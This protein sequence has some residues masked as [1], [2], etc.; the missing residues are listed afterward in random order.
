M[1]FKNVIK[2]VAFIAIFLIILST[3]S[4]FFQKYNSQK[5]I[6]Y[7]KKN[8]IDYLVLGDSEAFTSI[9]PMEIWNKHGFTGYNLGAPG[10]RL[11]KTYYLFDKVLKNQKPK[12][13]LLETNSAYRGFR[14]S[15]EINEISR[16]FLKNYFAVYEHHNRWKSFKFTSEKSN[17][18]KS[19]PSEVNILKGFRCNTKIESYKK[20]NYIR[21]TKKTK[22]IPKVPRYYLNKIIELCNKNDI[23]L[24]LYTV[25]TPVNWSYEKHNAI[26]NFAKENKLPLI[27]LNLK[28]DVIKMDWIK[29]T[30]DNGD[31]INFYGSKK[32]TNYMG[33]YLEKN[34]SLI[35]HRK[36]KKYE[37]WNDSWKEYLNL[38]SKF[39][40]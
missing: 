15:K 2:P 26:N 4:L 24:I 1:K 7:E 40:K 30:Y 9:S 37:Y 11:Q 10:E 8:T 33:N 22:E 31:H 13:V 20:G 6:E 39:K 3:L 12:V 21:K 5:G 34:T 35:D 25:P 32:V 16:D 23:Q 28:N 14:I 18:V 19:R 38:I 17:N 29:D 27:D 36:D